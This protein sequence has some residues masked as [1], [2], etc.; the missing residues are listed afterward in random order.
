MRAWRK[1]LAAG[2]SLLA[3]TIAAHA[4]DQRA[5]QVINESEPTLCAEKDNV[6]LKLQSGEVRRFTV[7]AV[8]P[9]YAGTIVVDRFAPDFA[10]CDMSNDPV[11]KSERRQVTLYESAEWRL[12][13]HTFDSFWRPNRVPVKVGDR[14]ESG[15]HLLQLWTSR[16]GGFDEVLVLYPADGY[17]R[18]RPMPPANLRWSAYGSSFLIGPVETAGRPIVDIKDVSYEPES[19]TFTL[20]FARGGSA[21]LRIETLNDERMVLDVN[22]SE[23]VGAQRPFAALRSMFV[24]EG[25]S[26]VARVGWRAKD[27]ERWLQEPVMEFK[28]ASAAELWAGRLVPSRHNMSAPDMVFRDFSA[29]AK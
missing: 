15:L 26:D 7:E 8:H 2:F 29:A 13:G 28:R 17:W 3:L 11:F 21:T 19:K 16:H 23:P 24:S 18:A 14:V 10:N 22:L 6:Y 1:W 27:S 9:A 5:V 25:N 12:V 20:N 4:A